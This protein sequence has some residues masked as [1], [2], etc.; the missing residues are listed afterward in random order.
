M[1]VLAVAG[2]VAAFGCTGT[3]D[4]SGDRPG[5]N[6]T[7]PTNPTNPGGGKT[8]PGGGTGSGGQSGVT[9]PPGV[10]GSSVDPIAPPTPVTPGAV[11]VGI[12][13]LRRLTSEQYRN[14]IRDLLLMKDARDTVSAGVLPS[15]DSIVDRFASNIISSVQ[16]L[17]ADK[18]ADLAE[19]LAA[20]AVTSLATLVSCAQTDATC[21]QKFIE[22]FGK[23][24]FRRPLS[25]VEVD[26]YK[27]VYMAGGNFSNGIKLVIQTFLQSPN[28]LYLVEPVP[29]DGAGKVL[30]ISNW[31]VA[32]RLSYFFLDSMPDD[33]LFAAAES[34]QLATPDQIGKQAT[35]LMTDPRFRETINFF[36]DQWLELDNLRSA[37]KDPMLFKAWNEALV[38]ALDEQMRRFI[39]GVLADGDGKLDTLLTASFSFLSGPL[40]DL[41]G[42][43]T[44]PTGAALTAWTKVD[45]NAKERAGLLTQAGLLAGLA[46]ENRTSYI[47]RGKMVREA[48][49]CA[50][51]P[52]PPAGVDASEMNIP[53]T[54]SARE[55]SMLH[56]TQPACAS[57]HALF[58]PLGFAFENYDATGRYRATD[59]A[60]KPIDAS[61]EISGTAKLD[62][63]VPNAIELVKKLATADEVRSCIARQWMRFGLGRELDDRDDAATMAAAGKAMNDS[64]GKISDL[65]VAF[66]RSDAFR[67]QKVKP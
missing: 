28:F 43:T 39:T 67:H 26:R 48:I 65:L 45:L 33:A 51:V 49:L 35:R 30:Q 42:V 36:H 13:P 53:A 6:P 17:D 62:G 22:S 41:Y 66:A 46:H 37:E 34:G 31:A 15:D 60:G 52:P 58:D 38:A 7:D 40:Y 16:G 29:A 50:D 54:A 8:P 64:G 14:T 9:N 10:G 59:A 4:G 32:S 11:N 3:V 61:A 5:T 57:C 56:R 18:Y 47:L 63:T 21:P 25:T 2:A 19:Q 24:A 20:K 55:R 44:K 27:K 23:R 1:R 12:S